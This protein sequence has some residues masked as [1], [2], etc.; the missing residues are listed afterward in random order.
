M[1]SGGIPWRYVQQKSELFRSVYKLKSLCH[2]L[3]LH[4]VGCGQIQEGLLC[5][6][7][8]KLLCY[9]TAEILQLIRFPTVLT[10]LNNNLFLFFYS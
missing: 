1:P 7:Y 9:K 2:E 8:R 5:D 10:F 3:C 6:G 4:F